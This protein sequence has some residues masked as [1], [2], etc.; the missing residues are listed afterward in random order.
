MEMG[1]N[2]CNRFPSID[3][4]G[5]AIKSSCEKV[6][7]KTKLSRWFKLFHCTVILQ[8]KGQALKKL[9]MGFYEVSFDLFVNKLKGP[10]P[11]TIQ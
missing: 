3:I 6:V 9:S 1:R 11:E 10:S 4:I 8:D 5:R 7:E 2:E